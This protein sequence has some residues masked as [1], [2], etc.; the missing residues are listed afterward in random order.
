MRTWTAVFG[1]KQIEESH[2][3]EMKM[4]NLLVFPGTDWLQKPLLKQEIPEADRKYTEPNDN[5]SP[6]PVSLESSDMDP[7]RKEGTDIQNDIGSDD[8]SQSAHEADAVLPVVSASP[9]SSKN[10]RVLHAFDH[11]YE[12]DVRDWCVENKCVDAQ[13]MKG[14]PESSGVLNSNSP[15]DTGLAALQE[16]NCVSCRQVTDITESAAEYLTGAN[17]ESNFR[18]TWDGES[19]TLLEAQSKLQLPL[20]ASDE[21]E[22]MQN[23]GNQCSSL[24]IYAD[25]SPEALDESTLIK[26]SP[27]PIRETSMQASRDTTDGTCMKFGCVSSACL[28]DEPLVQVSSALA[29]GTVVDG[30]YASPTCSEICLITGASVPAKV[31]IFHGNQE[32]SVVEDASSNDITEGRIRHHL[33]APD[34]LEE[35]TNQNI[36]EELKKNGDPNPCPSP[37][38]CDAVP[39]RYPTPNVQKIAEVENKLLTASNSGSGLV[40]PFDFSDEQL[41]TNTMEATEKSVASPCLD[42]SSGVV[43]TPAPKNEL[44]N[45][46]PLL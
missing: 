5:S 43:P 17:N 9:A 10:R 25:A 15:P 6:G 28:S 34:F 3:N 14:L 2:R 22:D 23:L 26:Q 32:F 20:E 29:Q 7:M 18:Q 31:D 35:A 40:H 44:D 19:I 21:A 36:A 42:G 39:Y 4:L 8:T 46:L 13:I 11:A 45:S 24:K 38:T 27:G 33:I 1:F 37:H 16:T 41:L 12:A 30:E